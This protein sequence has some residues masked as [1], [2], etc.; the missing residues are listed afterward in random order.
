MLHGQPRGVSPPASPPGRL[1][2]LESSIL[3]AASATEKQTST[4]SI[5][6]QQVGER[7]TGA[8]VGKP[9]CPCKDQACDGVSSHVHDQAILPCSSAC[10]AAP[11]RVARAPAVVAAFLLSA[12]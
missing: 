8:R 3:T 11:V 4:V 5:L 7:A 9:L 2:D 10:P 6:K 1:F 12:L